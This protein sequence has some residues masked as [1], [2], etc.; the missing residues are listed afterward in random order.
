[1]LGNKDL[2]RVLMS[3]FI[4]ILHRDAIRIKEDVESNRDISKDSVGR[5]REFLDSCN[6]GEKIVP[7][8]FKK[9]LENLGKDTWKDDRNYQKLFCPVVNKYKILSKNLET[10]LDALKRLE[11]R[12]EDGARLLENLFNEMSDYVNRYPLGSKD[13]YGLKLAI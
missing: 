5:I 9:L 11:N 4:G 13:S 3:Y 7:Y 12:D 6:R 1:M 2:E 8:S 10:Y